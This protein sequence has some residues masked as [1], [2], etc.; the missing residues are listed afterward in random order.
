MAN[1]KKSYEPRSLVRTSLRSLGF[2]LPP[3]KGVK[4][5]TIVRK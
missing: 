3:K 5:V 1:E 4:L 2:Y